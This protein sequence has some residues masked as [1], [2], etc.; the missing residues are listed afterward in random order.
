MKKTGTQKTR[1]VE[2][3]L[4]SVKTKPKNS[5]FKDVQATIK[6][7]LLQQAQATLWQK[8]LADLTKEYQGKVSYQAS[9]APP[10]TTALPATRR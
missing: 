3:I 2:H 5:T 10:T 8:W 4:V 6:Q 7:T 9:Y 1:S